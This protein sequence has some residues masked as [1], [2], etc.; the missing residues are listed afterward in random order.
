MI[1]GK[2]I[3]KRQE[4][5]ENFNDSL[6]LYIDVAKSWILKCIKTPLV[7]LLQD[8]KTSLDFVDVYT[9]N[10]TN[11]NFRKAKVRAEAILDT[12]ILNAK[13]KDVPYSL[14]MFFHQLTNHNTFIPNNFLTTFEL[15]RITVNKYGALQNPT[16]E[17]KQMMIGFFLL[18]KILIGTILL[19]P[20]SVGVNV[21][22]S[23][24][25]MKNF[26]IVASIIWQA[27]L[28]Y[29]KTY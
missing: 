4:E 8:Q 6:L 9:T 28:K 16:P 22:I 15:H 18:G 21:K 24:V 27:F 14:L 23:Q 29:I 7:S 19:K 12:M 1:R 25:A 2:E 20:Q 17:V 3:R 10:A 11:T 13:P 5:I 26:K